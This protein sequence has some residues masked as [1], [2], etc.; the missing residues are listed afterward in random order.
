MSPIAAHGSNTIVQLTTA[1]QSVE[2][3]YTRAL[4]DMQVELEVA[5]RERDALERELESMTKKYEAQIDE[6][7]AA[8]PLYQDPDS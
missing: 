6:L 4:A 3:F 2:E 8:P 5:R 1:L 7:K